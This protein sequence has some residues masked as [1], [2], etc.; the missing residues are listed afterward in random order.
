MVPPEEFLGIVPSWIIVYLATLMCFGVA[1]VILYI[2][3][4]RP[5]LSGRPS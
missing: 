3:M 4:F 1:T 5:I 2:R